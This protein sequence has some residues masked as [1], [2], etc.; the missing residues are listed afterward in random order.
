[1]L[2]L[3]ASVRSSS[4]ACT[5]NKAIPTLTSDIGSARVTNF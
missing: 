5:V 1:M 2:R 4:L 3:F